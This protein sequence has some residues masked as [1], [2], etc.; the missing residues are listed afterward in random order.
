ME[1]NLN[2]RIENIE[3]EENFIKKQIE[4]YLI[5]SKKESNDSD[6]KNLEEGF[7]YFCFIFT[8]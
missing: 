5:Y 8:K 1:N 2:K 7:L 3:K 6:N 4:S